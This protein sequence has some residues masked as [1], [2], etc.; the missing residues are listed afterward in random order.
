MSENT[1]QET[2]QRVKVGFIVN[3]E[4]VEIIDTDERIASILLGSPLVL[5]VTGPNGSAKTFISDTYD[6][7]QNKFAAEDTLAILANSALINNP[8]IPTE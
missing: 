6:P 3:N 5:D 2:G 7:E 1:N 8:D 4:V